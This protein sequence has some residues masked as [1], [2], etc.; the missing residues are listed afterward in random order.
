LFF[1]TVPT[2]NTLVRWVNENAFAPI[3]RARPCPT[4]GRP[5]HR[6]GSPHRLRPGTSPHTLRIPPHGGHPVLRSNTES[7][8]RFTLAVSSFRFRA[9]LGFS[10]PSLS[11]GQR[12]ITPA[13]GYSAPHPGAGGTLTLLNSALLSAHYRMIRHLQMHRYF[14]FVDLTYRF[15]LSITWR[16]PMFRLP[17]SLARRGFDIV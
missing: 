11:S 4:F 17:A 12:G 1:R 14:P 5:V 6:R 2:A 10:I 15:S 16:L 8:F 3:V 13:F 9:R 7:G